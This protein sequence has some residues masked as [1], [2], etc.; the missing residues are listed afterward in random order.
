[1]TLTPA[2]NQSGTTTITLTLSDGDL[3]TQQQFTLTVNPVNDAPIA[4]NDAATTTTATPVNI[5]VLNNDEDPENDA[6]ALSLAAL[7]QNG[8]AQIN[9]NGTPDD[10]RDDFITYTPIA[11][12]IG[13]DTFSYRV[14]D[15][16]SG[17]ATAQVN[18]TVNPGQSLTQTGNVLK[19]NGN[20][21]Q[22]KLKASLSSKQSQPFVINEIGVFVVED[23]QGRVNGLLPGTT[24]YVQAAL[25]KAQ[26]I[27]SVLPDNFIANPT[28]ILEGFEGNLLSFYLI[29]NGTTDAILNN[30]SLSNKVLLGTPLNG[31]TTDILNIQALGTNQFSLAFDDQLG[32]RNSDLTIQI[33]VT[34]EPVPI[35]SGLVSIHNKS[36]KSFKYSV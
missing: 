1:L 7:P 36:S 4:R 12:F 14:S 24:G 10:Q 25:E 21:D 5:N 34:D 22:L 8:T 3:T 32:D 33:E 19:W 13:T 18:I 30:L 29:Q 28:R 11:G 26:V 23:E 27:F 17:E 9:N 31:Q 15:G 20:P 2:A 16:N 35:G 6:L